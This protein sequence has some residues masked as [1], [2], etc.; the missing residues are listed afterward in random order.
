MSEE[1]K[2]NEGVINLSEKAKKTIEAQVNKVLKE[3][4]ALGEIG[5]RNRD[6]VSDDLVEKIFE[7]IKKKTAF[8]KKQFKATESHDEF[9]L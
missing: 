6:E 5:I 2:N 1:N 4:S 9:K 8:A 7:H 3:L